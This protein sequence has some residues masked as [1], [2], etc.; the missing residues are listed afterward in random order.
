MDFTLEDTKSGSVKHVFSELGTH[1]VTVTAVDADGEEL[2]SDS[3]EIEVSPYFVGEVDGEQVL[4]I[5]ADQESGSRIRVHGWRNFFVSVDRD[6]GR[7]DADR[8]EVFGS[9]SRD[10]VLLFGQFSAS[11][12]L[13]GGRDFVRSIFSDVDADLGDGR[14]FAL[15]V[16]SDEVDFRGGEGRDRL[17]SIGHD[18]AFIDAGDGRDFVYTRGHSSLVVGGRGADRLYAFDDYSVVVADELEYT[19]EIIDEVFAELATGAP[20]WDLLGGMLEPRITDDGARDRGIQWG[21]GGL[22]LQEDKDRIWS[23]NRRN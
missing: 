21:F 20:D 1:T 15:A 17:Y 5:G 19:P 9:D 4:F 2:A 16:W 6:R 8:V 10:T 23:F 3:K 12:S 13:G 18:Q 14:D 7:V 22:L 11:L